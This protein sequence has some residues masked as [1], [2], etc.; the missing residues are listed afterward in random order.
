MPLYET[1]K[2][3]ADVGEDV[4][5]DKGITSSEAERKKVVAMYPDDSLVASNLL[6]AL[7]REKRVNFRIDLLAGEASKRV[8][9]DVEVPLGHTFYPGYHAGAA[10]GGDKYV[11]IEYEITG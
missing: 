10:E 2:V 3:T 1:F 9:V 7:E 5:S 6:G 4:Y 8:L 11:V